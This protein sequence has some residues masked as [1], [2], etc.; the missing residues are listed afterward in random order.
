MGGI[1]TGASAENP[2]IPGAWTVSIHAVTGLLI[3]FSAYW[4]ML[5]ARRLDR[6]GSAVMARTQEPLAASS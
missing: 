5:R 1:L 6:T 4:L 2:S 3:I